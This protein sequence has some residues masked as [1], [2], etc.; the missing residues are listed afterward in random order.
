MLYLSLAVLCSVSIGMIFK[1]AG[2]RQLDRTALLTINYAAAVGVAGVLIAI[3]GRGASD[4]LTLSG[5]LL[6]LGIGTGALLIFGFFMLMVA[7]DV[8]GMGLSIGVMRVSVVL[9]F[10]ASWLIWAEEPSVM[11]LIGMGCAA[12]AFF[13]IAQTP[14]GSAD[15]IDEPIRNSEP[16]HEGVPAT[17]GAYVTTA[18][19][20]GE[21]AP[22]ESDVFVEEERGLDVPEPN[23]KVLGTLFILF[24]SGGAVD[25][26]MKTFQEGFGADNSR[27]M[28]LLLAFGISFL[29]GL[30]YVVQKGIRTGVWPDRQTWVW[31]IGLGIINY[32][33]LEFLLRALEQLPGTVVFPINNISIVV[34]AALLGVAFWRERLTK[35]N[36]WG[37]ALAVV[38]LVL[39]SNAELLTRVQS[40]FGI[41]PA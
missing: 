36:I 34:L 20:E 15:A 2:Q 41:G 18:A 39:L 6:L 31:G 23:A 28:F 27:F 26:T 25:I 40:L 3:G 21:G 14:D 17:A 7:T 12:V 22:E 33:S 9:P 16:V 1:V 4:G 30:V 38:G 8:A 11:Q 32:G 24:L 19:S 5:P 29:I 10:L 35:T 37:L 13:L